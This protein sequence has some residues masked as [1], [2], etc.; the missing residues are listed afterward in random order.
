MKKGNGLTRHH[1]KSK[2][3][4]GT[5]EQEN[6]SMVKDKFHQ[7]FHLLFGDADPGYIVE[8]LNSIWIDPDYCVVLMKRKQILELANNVKL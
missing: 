4:G 7:A 8:Q 3:R 6:I 2:A 1:R 5:N